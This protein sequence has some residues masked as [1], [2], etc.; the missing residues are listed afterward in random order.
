MGPIVFTVATTKCLEEYGHEKREQLRN[1]S[2]L[3]KSRIEAADKSL[4]REDRE[5]G[6]GEDGDFMDEGGGGGDDP[7]D[8]SFL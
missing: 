1:M 7:D 2:I 5:G 8:D 3:T 6:E 4:F